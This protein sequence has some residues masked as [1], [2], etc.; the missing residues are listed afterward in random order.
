VR[1]PPIDDDRVGNPRRPRS[2]GELP[3]QAVDLGK[4]SAQLRQPVGVGEARGWREAARSGCGLC[5]DHQRRERQGGAHA[6]DAAEQ[7]CGRTSH[8]AGDARSRG[9]RL[10]RP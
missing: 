5:F 8:G 1:D 7:P 6:K 4:C 9:L 10:G 2:L 3:H